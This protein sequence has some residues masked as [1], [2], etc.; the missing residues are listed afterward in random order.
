MIR[1]DLVHVGR[2]RESVAFALRISSNGIQFDTRP[3]VG[4]IGGVGDEDRR[5]V[6]GER[7]V[8]VL[9]QVQ[10][11]GIGSSP[12]TNG[13]E[14]GVG[15]LEPAAGVDL[16]LAAVVA[17]VVEGDVGVGIIDPGDVDADQARM[18]G[19]RKCRRNRRCWGWW[20]RPR[21]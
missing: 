7:L 17:A 20:D 16:E 15:H 6:A 18:S 10:V 4:E 8:R 11:G 13:R 9:D 21:G 1:H 3:V 2:G 14:L 19:R 5:A 12:N